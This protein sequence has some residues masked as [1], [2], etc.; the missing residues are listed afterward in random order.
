MNHLDPVEYAATRITDCK[1]DV[2]M[3]LAR[4][5]SSDRALAI[6]SMLGAVIAELQ[7]TENAALCRADVLPAR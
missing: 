3:E 7:Q 1:R 4:A 5:R 6:A 2:D